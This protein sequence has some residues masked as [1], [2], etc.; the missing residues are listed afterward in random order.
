MFIVTKAYTPRFIFRLSQLPFTALIDM[1]K[2]L[3]RP[4]CAMSMGKGLR[5]FLWNACS[6]PTCKALPSKHLL[7]FDWQGA[8]LFRAF[9]LSLHAVYADLMFPFLDEHHGRLGACLGL[10]TAVANPWLHFCSSMHSVH[11][12]WALDLYA[13]AWPCRTSPPS[14]STSA[15][16]HP[17]DCLG[18]FMVSCSPWSFLLHFKFCLYMLA[19]CDFCSFI[20]S[21]QIFS[22]PRCPQSPLCLPYRHGLDLLLDFWQ[23]I[24]LP[25]FLWWL[26]PDVWLCIFDFLPV[27]GLLGLSQTSRYIRMLLKCYW[28]WAFS[29]SKLLEPFLPNV[30]VDDFRQVL[31]T[32]GRIISGLVALQFLDRR[33]FDGESNLDI[34]VPDDNASIVTDWFL[35]LGLTESVPEQTSIDIMSD[36]NHSSEIKHVTNFL[37]VNSIRV[38]QLILTKR[39]P[40]FAVFDFHSS[41]WFYV[42]LLT[43]MGSYF[44]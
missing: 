22:P 6:L 7:S 32:S 17:W 36:Y 30:N 44:F 27:E 1:R 4:R 2:Y 38:I 15:S 29:L 28:K 23:K 11:L 33:I 9:R 18:L 41:A 43:R 3:S 42:L 8:A 26:V 39:D 40:A 24:W 12:S 34:Y 16:L 25:S 14:L 31:Q 10:A 5:S 21:C 35:S 19:N 13:H 20:V 37:A